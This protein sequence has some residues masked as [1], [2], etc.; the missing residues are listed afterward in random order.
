MHEGNDKSQYNL[1]SQGRV[2]KTPSSTL[3]YGSHNR[4]EKIERIGKSSI[5]YFYDEAGNRI[6]KKEGDW[7]IEAYFEDRVI[8]NDGL[9]GTPSKLMGQSLEF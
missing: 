8:S 7:M 3:I 1:D 9:Y 4:V 6:L 2:V 5:T